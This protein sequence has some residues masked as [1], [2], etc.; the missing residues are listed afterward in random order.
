MRARSILARAVLATSTIALTALAPGIPAQAAPPHHI[1]IADASF[2][3]GA[4]GSANLSFTI[5]VS[6]PGAAGITV[7]YATAN[8]TATA[9]SDYT[10]TSGTAAL[11]N[12]GCKCAIVNVPILGDTTPEFNETFQVNLSNPV[13]GTITDSQAIGTITNDDD[14]HATIDDPSALEN[15][16][17]LAFTV[18]L[19][20][21]APFDS[22]MT[23]ATTD[24]TA[25]AGADYTAASG[26]LTILA[27][28]TSGTIDVPLLDD[29]VAEGDE[30]LT[31]DL[32]A[33]SGVVLDDTQGTGTITDDEAPV[34]ISVDD[35]VVSEADGTMTFTISQTGIV[36]LD[37]TVDYGTVDV[38]ATDGADY[39]GQTGTATILAGD[40][41]TTVS[42]P[43]ADDAL[44]EGDESLTLDLSG[45]SGGSVVDGQGLGTVTDDDPLPTIDVDSPTVGEADGTGSFTISLDTAAG[46]DVSVDYTTSDGTATDG[47]DYTGG[48]GTA[49]ILAGDSSTTVDLPVL[50]D[51]T[52]EGDED[53]TI[54][55]SNEVNGVLGTSTGT[56]TITDDDGAPGVSIADAGT[57]EGNTATKKLNL[58]VSLT[59]PTT[60]DISVDFATSNQTATAGSDYVADAGTVTILAGDTLGQVQVTINGDSTF[61]ADETLTVTLSSVAGTATL[62]TAISTGTIRNDDKQAAT[63]TMKISKTGTRVLAKGLLEAAS[64]GNTVKVT[65][66]R[67][68]NG[69]WVK[70]SSKSVGVKKFLDRDSDGK[71]DAKYTGSFYRPTKGRYR[72]TA[73]FAGDADS[74][75]KTKKVTFTL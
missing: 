8:A 71:T 45:A 46:V 74:L 55:L 48:I 62:D 60:E 61:E 20:Q 40:T 26:T 14:P 10:S 63:L 75:A 43:V 7:D 3:E 67:Y 52:F 28:D 33:V 9:G 69:K 5:L 16:G 15:S 34:D 38:S 13:G 37:I 72:F 31:T 24:G 56:A 12:G 25:T 66:A 58:L 70:I 32:V 22:V 57:P 35:Q 1:T 39:T 36:G 19:D 54:D 41:S 49:T 11:A 50:D 29:A 64:T 59:N 17:P 44:Y 18:T 65:L 21:T 51:T 23:Y 6:G 53:F 73:Q 42:V 27:G 2:A 30:D 68:Q 4:S 47:L